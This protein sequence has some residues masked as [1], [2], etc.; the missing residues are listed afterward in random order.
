M[1]HFPIKHNCIEIKFQFDGHKVGR[2]EGKGSGG[3]SHRKKSKPTALLDW[4]WGDVL[5]DR[6]GSR[7]S[8][9]MSPRPPALCL[10]NAE[11]GAMCVSL[12]KRRKEQTEGLR[13]HGCISCPYM[14]ASKHTEVDNGHAVTAILFLWGRVKYEN[15]ISNLNNFRLLY[16][17]L[18]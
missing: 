8:V 14:L 18:W 5:S 3:W 1:I 12:G 6:M 9:T 10:R 13:Q 16:L 15:K 4:R 11:E 2:D 17:S 7:V